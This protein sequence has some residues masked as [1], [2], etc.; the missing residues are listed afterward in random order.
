MLIESYIGYQALSKVEHFD[1]IETWDTCMYI[2]FVFYILF[3]VL[4]IYTIVHSI[5]LT[6]KKKTKNS[7]VALLSPLISWPFYWLFYYN[8]V[9]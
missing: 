3:V 5:R 6:R 7:T 4:W 8:N 9:I 1:S 2:F